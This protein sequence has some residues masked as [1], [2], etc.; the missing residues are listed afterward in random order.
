MRPDPLL[1]VQDLRVVFGEG[2]AARAALDGVSFS[3]RKGRTLAVVG[4]SGCGKSLTALS[5][6]RLL[7][8]PPARLVGGRILFSPSDG[9]ARDLARLDPRSM[10]SLRG[11]E[12][13]M[14][15]QDPMTAL[16][17]VYPIGDQIAE[18]LIEHENLSRDAAF[19]KAVGLLQLVGVPSPAE[20]ARQYP[21]EFSGGMR[22]R[23]VI[24]VAL[25]CNPALLIADEPTTALDVTVQA[26]VLRLMR[27]LQE[28]LGSSILFITHDMGV[29][30]QMAED[31]I[32]MYLGQVV[33]EGPVK[34]VLS[35]PAH[36]YTQG[37]IASIPTLTMPRGKALQ[38]IA[39][40]VP[41]IGSITSGCRFRTRCPYAM[42]ICE[43]DPPVLTT[44]AGTRAA[45][46]LLEE[47][48]P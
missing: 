23:A 43:R 16:D 28:R 41:S 7:P 5:I 32:V 34:A 11:K 8:E 19:A 12:I 25:A 15:F 27:S 40:V 26:Q 30:G 46:W 24:A 20:R 14:I 1:E 36:P 39:G 45:C 29:V 3:I 48:A 42:P 13:A 38:P 35:S 4:E 31:V 37:L 10:R 6:M 2:R 18:V 21:H 22:Q 44:A 33:E 17:P 9:P 47:G